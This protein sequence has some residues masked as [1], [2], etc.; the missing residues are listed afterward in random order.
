[1][2]EYIGDQRYMFIWDSRKIK[3]VKDAQ[4]LFEGNQREGNATMC[5]TDEAGQ[6]IRDPYF[7]NFET[8]RLKFSI[9]NVN[10][11][12]DFNISGWEAQYVDRIMKAMYGKFTQYAPVFVMGTMN[13]CKDD[14][15]GYFLGYV[16]GNISEVP[17]LEPYAKL[18][19]EWLFSDYEDL[20]YYEVV[21]NNGDSFGDNIINRCPESNMVYE[22]HFRRRII[23][24]DIVEDYPSD[25]TENIP[26]SVTFQQEVKYKGG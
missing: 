3:D 26:I 5:S 18:K 24:S 20:E 25:V 23:D 6:M 7:M 11:D 10:M 12:E 21:D 2:S 4:V 22:E 8:E 15:H 19:Y 1:M 17:F 13:M 16:G 14:L 9:I